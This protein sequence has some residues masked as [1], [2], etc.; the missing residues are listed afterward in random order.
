MPAS[1]RASNLRI[2]PFRKVL[3]FFIE[4]QE[5]L[6]NVFVFLVPKNEYFSIT[7][8]KSNEGKLSSVPKERI[9]SM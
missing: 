7:F 3:N 2:L 8:L 9:S 4:L 5:F 6:K 1:R